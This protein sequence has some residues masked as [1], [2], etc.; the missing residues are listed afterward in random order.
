MIY[1]R[2]SL[3]RAAVLLA[4]YSLARGV[5]IYYYIKSWAE[6]LYGKGSLGSCGMMYDRKSLGSAAVI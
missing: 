3:V 2:K 5:M 1:G 6:V 4:K